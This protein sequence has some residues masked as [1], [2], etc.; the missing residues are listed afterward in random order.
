[1]LHLHRMDA[2]ARR[3]QRVLQRGEERLKQLAQ[4]QGTTWRKDDEITSVASTTTNVPVKVEDDV[5]LKM[6]AT[7][8][9][10]DASK[11]NNNTDSKPNERSNIG[12]IGSES[13]PSA[14]M[15][16]KMPAA[17]SSFP[18]AASAASR[19][20]RVAAV[21]MTILVATAARATGLVPERVLY[22]GPTALFAVLQVFFAT[23]H[24]VRLPAAHL[25]SYVCQRQALRCSAYLMRHWTQLCSSLRIR[26]LWRQLSSSLDG[27][28]IFGTNMPVHVLL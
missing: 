22:G 2:A 1:M 25:C 26:W 18:A 16:S 23:W 10:K 24:Q 28:D 4:A 21:L 19:T 9:T 8:K 12:N 5:P 14:T 15:Q 13:T 6:A 27:F 7:L 17:V 11:D 3:R 20:A